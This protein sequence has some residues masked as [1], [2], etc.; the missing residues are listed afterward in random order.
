MLKK[1]FSIKSSS[2][3][4]SIKNVEQKTINR[5]N[6][7]IEKLESDETEYFASN[8]KGLLPHLKHGNCLT[9]M[10][11]NN[12]Y[13]LKVGTDRA[14]A[15]ILEKDNQKIYVWFWGGTHEKYNELLKAKKL[16]EKGRNVNASS[17]TT[18]SIQTKMEEMRKQAQ[19]QKPHYSN[20]EYNHYDDNNRDN[21]KHNYEHNMGKVYDAIDKARKE[22]NEKD[23]SNKKHQVNSHG[24]KR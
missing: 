11:Q 19:T 1:C 12:I 9:A 18:S 22:S 2:F 17:E 3:E 8:T 10:G 6:A 5:I 24:K 15:S 14:I 7:A 23:N 21:K 16:Q 4:K 20:E 13:V